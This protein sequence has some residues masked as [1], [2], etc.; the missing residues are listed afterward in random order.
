VAKAAVCKTVI[1]RFESGCRLQRIKGLTFTVDP[2]SVSCCRLL[3]SHQESLFQTVPLEKTPLMAKGSFHDGNTGIMCSFFLLELP[4]FSSGHSGLPC[5]DL[6]TNPRIAKVFLF[7]GSLLAHPHPPGAG[8]GDAESV[9]SQG[10]C[11]SKPSNG[12]GARPPSKGSE[13][14]SY[15]F[16]ER[17]SSR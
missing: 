4:L 16:L 15:G 17:Y 2:F 9:G 7:I 14:G 11:E 6:L 10:V 5:L 13:R 3:A 12:G 8:K 1:H